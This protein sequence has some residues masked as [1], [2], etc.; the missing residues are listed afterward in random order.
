MMVLDLVN[1]ILIV[2]GQVIQPRLP[3]NHQLPIQHQDQPLDL[4]HHRQ[5]ILQEI[6][7]KDQPINH[8]V[9]PPKNQHLLQPLFHQ[10]HHQN[11]PL[12]PLPIL[13]HKTLKQ[14]HQP[15]TLLRPQ[16]DQRLVHLKVQPNHHLPIQ[17]NPLRH[18]HQRTH[19]HHLQN[20]P[21]NLPQLVLVNRPQNH[22]HWDQQ[23]VHYQ[24]EQHMNLLHLHLDHLLGIHLRPHLPKDLLQALQKH[25]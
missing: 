10:I 1:P 16:T 25:Q 8:Q 11:D 3:P 22:P 24:L 4:H 6:L 7:P 17:P 13:Q 21:L 5:G 23:E 2:I 20:H 18:R 12:H 14:K 9:L 15:V 19:R